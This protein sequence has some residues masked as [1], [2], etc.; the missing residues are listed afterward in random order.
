M[1]DHKPCTCHPDDAPPKCQRLYAAG[2]CQRA[3]TR[4]IANDMLRESLRDGWIM[5]EHPVRLL[6]GNDHG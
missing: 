4:V 2:D 3:Y 1:T 5:G 6:R